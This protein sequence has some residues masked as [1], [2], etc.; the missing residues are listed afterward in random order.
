[1][2]N[3]VKFDY[4]SD[5]VFRDKQVHNGQKL[6]P[7]F[8]LVLNIF[9]IKKAAVISNFCLIGKICHDFLVPTMIKLGC[10]TFMPFQTSDL[11]RVNMRKVVRRLDLYH[12]STNS[13]VKR[14]N[15]FLTIYLS[16]FILF[17]ICLYIFAFCQ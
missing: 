13:K 4:F 2:F 6:A 7:N 17:L 15:A 3:L 9:T 1:M 8:C 11:H 14:K 10:K 12:L 16:H 5:S